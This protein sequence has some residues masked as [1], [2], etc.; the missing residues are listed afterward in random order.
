V[1]GWVRRSYASA[2][3][4]RQPEAFDLDHLREVETILVSTPKGYVETSSLGPAAQDG[5]EKRR[6]AR[7]EAARDAEHRVVSLPLGDSSLDA[8]VIGGAEMWS[9]GFEMPPDPIPLSVLLSGGS[10]PVDALR[11]ELV[12]DLLMRLDQTGLGSS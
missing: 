1:D 5:E 9:A 4:A 7:E 2:R 12:D 3:F 8:T 6:L 10:V 11:L